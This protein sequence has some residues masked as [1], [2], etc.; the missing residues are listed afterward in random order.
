MAVLYGGCQHCVPLSPPRSAGSASIPSLGI[1]AG[2][3]PVCA[4]CSGAFVLH[5]SRLIN[6]VLICP[7][8]LQHAQPDHEIQIKP[9]PHKHPKKS[10]TKTNRPLRTKLQPAAFAP[11]KLTVPPELRAP[12]P[13]PHQP[14]PAKV[15]M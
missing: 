14:N 6:I 15:A 9:M 7:G 1:S 11:P 2:S 10:K 5:I 13:Q 12:R 3:L 4:G 8:R